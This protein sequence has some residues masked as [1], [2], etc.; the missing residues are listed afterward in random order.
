LSDKKTLIKLHKHTSF[1]KIVLSF[2]SIS[3]STL[4][5]VYRGLTAGSR[6]VLC[7]FWIA[8]HLTCTVRETARRPIFSRVIFSL[9][10]QLRI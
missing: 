4:A 7:N 9:T 8:R 3:R 2:W 5:S 10:V 6:T 1:V